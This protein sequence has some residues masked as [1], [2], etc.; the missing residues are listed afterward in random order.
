MQ[1]VSSKHHD[2]G[3][4]HGRKRRIEPIF[5]SLK[6]AFISSSGSEAFRKKKGS[7]HILPTPVYSHACSPTSL[8]ATSKVLGL[9]YLSLSLEGLGETAH[10]V[11][12]GTPGA[13]ELDVG[14]VD[15]DLASLA[16]LDVLLAAEGGEAPV[17]GDDD[18]LATGELVL[19]A[20]ESLNDV[21][22]D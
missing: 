11:L 1:I 6:H 7:K 14:T 15:A 12:K 8:L 4:S 3:R 13:E 19:G 5:V 2:R 10:V 17:L 21:G 22:A 20:T 16:L 9:G 18:L